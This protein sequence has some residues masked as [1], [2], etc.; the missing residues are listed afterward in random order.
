MVFY[1]GSEIGFITVSD[2][3]NYPDVTQAPFGIPLPD[4][5]SFT[6]IKVCGDLLFIS[7]KDDPNPGTLHIFDS[8][9]RMA[10]GSLTPPALIQSVSVIGVGPDNILV[11]KD[12]MTVA[13]ANE[14]EGDYED[15]LVNPVGS[16][17]IFNGP[18]DNKSLPP[19]T[20]LVSLDK[21]T[22]QELLDMGVHMPL[23]LNAM[24]YWDA[25]DDIDVDFADAIASYT[26]DA[27]LEPEYLAFNADESQIFV[28]LQENN[29]MVIID[30]A[31]GLADSIHP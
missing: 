1:G 2:F 26:P 7:T 17:T 28:N 14:G 23:T 20:T 4:G 10:D 25:T 5:A 11:S 18:F 24:I 9:K 31:T 6:D 12:C 3:S 16:V 22:E 27:V 30:V 29:A 19:M 8:S 13:T 15:F 21:W